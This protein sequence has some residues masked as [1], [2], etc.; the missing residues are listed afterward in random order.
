MI[1]VIAFITAKPGQR[2]ALLRDFSEVIPAVH[3]EQG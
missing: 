2:E 3:A 1:H